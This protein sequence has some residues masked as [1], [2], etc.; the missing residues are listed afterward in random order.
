MSNTKV[1][2]NTF[3]PN[4]WIFVPL[5]YIAAVSVD[6]IN[7]AQSTK[8]CKMFASERH[9]VHCLQQQLSHK[10]LGIPDSYYL[11]HNKAM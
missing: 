7:I 3:V 10:D 6:L 1:E 2:R 8:A 11:N 5:L 9:P 4:Y